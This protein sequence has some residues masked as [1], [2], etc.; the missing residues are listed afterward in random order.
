MTCKL[1][2]C[3][4]KSLNETET[5]ILFILCAIYFQWWLYIFSM[6]GKTMKAVSKDTRLIK[7]ERQPP[8]VK[9][10]ISFKNRHLIIQ[11]RFNKL[12]YGSNTVIK[13]DT[14]QHVKFQWVSRSRNEVILFRI[15]ELM[16][17]T[18]IQRYEKK[19]IISFL[20]QFKKRETNWNFTGC[21]MSHFMIVLILC[22]NLLN[23]S[24]IKIDTN[25]NYLKERCI[26]RWRLQRL[27]TVDNG[28]N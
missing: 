1:Q 7:S 20:I 10:S 12:I 8:N 15:S 27:I 19:K 23:L 3:H 25:E 5:T 9:G 28:S 4:M 13:C 11:E 22:F 21:Q 16:L 18:L 6:T 26:K 24:W 17:P 2:C 14:W